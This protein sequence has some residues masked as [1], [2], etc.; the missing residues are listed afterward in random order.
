MF[1]LGVVLLPGAQLPLH[2]FEPRYREL[3]ASA[4]AADGRFGLVFRDEG[5]P[6]R[7][8]TG[9]TG[10][11]AEIEQHEPLADGRSNI[12]VRGRE[13]FTIAAWQDDPAPWHVADVAWVADEPDPLAGLALSGAR[14]RQ[15]F[16]RIAEASRVMADESAGPPP[17]PD[18]PVRLAWAIAA[19]I[20][21]PPRDRQRLLA[22]RSPAAR[23]RTL[24][25]LL[26]PAAPELEQ[27]AQVHE[28]AKTNGHGSHHA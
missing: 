25:A 16:A 23:L 17:L 7:V 24:E 10:C 6:E 28:R 14:V 22:E 21:Q 26:A 20:D 12:V 11:V 3:V 1:P 27:R 9:T 15:L 13:R 8:P 2:I 5:Q 4:L 18:D 19:M